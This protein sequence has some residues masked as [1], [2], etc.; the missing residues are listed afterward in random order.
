MFVPLLSALTVAKVFLVLKGLALECWSRV[1]KRSS[2]LSNISVSYSWLAL[3]SP[4]QVQNAAIDDSL[5][6]IS[7]LF[8]LFE[9]EFTLTHSALN[10]SN[11]VPCQPL[12]ALNGL[13]LNSTC[14]VCLHM[15]LG[16][17]VVLL[18]KKNKCD[19]PFFLVSLNFYQLYCLKTL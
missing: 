2:L 1:T 4:S 5:Y 7:Y 3:H 8:F 18:V 16:M 15:I 17:R 14:C 11:A 10:R 6:W 13:S 19:W 9:T 12:P